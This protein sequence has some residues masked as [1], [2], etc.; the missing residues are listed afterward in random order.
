MRVVKVAVTLA[1]RSVA[2]LSF[3]TEGR[4]NV[5]PPGGWW[6]NQAIGAWGR[7]ATPEAIAAEV[8]RTAFEQPVVSH[9]VIADD[10]APQDRTFRNAWVD[11]GKS[12]VHDMDKAKQLKREH[13]RH[14]RAGLFPVLD[15]Q[16]SRAFGQ[17]KADE[18]AAV[19]RRRQALR[20]IPADPRIE[21]ATTVADLHA[22]KLPE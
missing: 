14:D 15:A 2:I 11:D 3:L 17:G 6:I 19:E 12:I 4:G 18:A 8:A 13:L 1:D 10:A 20:D 16:W 5:L 7:S 22:I 21:T 9:R